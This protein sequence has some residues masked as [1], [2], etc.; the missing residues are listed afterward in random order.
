[1]IGSIIGKIGTAVASSVAKNTTKKKTTASN[2]TNPST[3]Q[4]LLGGGSNE[5]ADYINKTNPGGLDAYTKLQNDRYNSALQNNDVDLLNKLNADAQ[6]VGYSFNAPKQEEIPQMKIPELKLPEYEKFNYEDFKYD[7]NFDYDEFNYKDFNYDV[8]NDNLYKVYADKYAREGQSASE[9]ALANTAA[10]TG[11]M[12]SSY[13]AAANSQAQQAYAK[14]TAD[15][16]P[17]LEGQAYDKYSNERNFSYQD[18]TNDRNLEYDKFNNDRNF[19]YQD[20]LNDRNLGYS[21]HQNVYNAELN[22]AQTMYNDG[23][24]KLNYAD[25]RNDLTYDRGK[26]QEAFDYEKFLNDQNRGDTL[27]QR[28]ID[29]TYR[30]GTFD[31]NVNTD[32]RDYNRNIYTDDRNYNYGVGQDSIRNNI[33]WANQGLSQSKF[34]YDKQQDELS[35]QDRIDAEQQ[36][37]IAAEEEAQFQKDVSYKISDFTA[38]ALKAKSPLE[39]LRTNAYGLTADEYKQVEDRIFKVLNYEK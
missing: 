21:E 12:P 14:K 7:K 20:Y 1:M 39:Y 3:Y 17:V 24:Q 37:K 15:M 29:N 16:I 10:A 28:D 34:E 27:S 11:G 18:Y 2:Y 33:S 25:S 31:W 23:W 26:Q 5:H 30:Q 36:L 35:R 13:A 22:N 8:N 6:R 38:E 32:E 4:N 19:S 9:Q